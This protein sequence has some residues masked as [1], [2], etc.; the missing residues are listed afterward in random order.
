[1]IA[2]FTEQPGSICVSCHGALIN[3]L[4]FAFEHYDAWALA[5]HRQRQPRRRHRQ[6]RVHRGK[7]ELRRRARVDGTIVSKGR[8]AH[9]C[10]A[11][12]LFEYLYGRDMTAGSA[13]DG[14]L[15][16]EVGR[17]SR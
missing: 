1:L 9:E 6:L 14:N 16:Q 12:R 2:A 11:R 15:I 7:E 5:R 17:R 10:Y 8:Q 13:A 3:P 4:G